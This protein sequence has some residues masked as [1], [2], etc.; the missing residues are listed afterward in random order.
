MARRGRQYPYH[1]TLMRQR[2]CALVCARILSS[3]PGTTSLH[4]GTARARATQQLEA[5]ASPAALQSTLAAL[6]ACA[7][8]LP[9]PA[10][11]LRLVGVVG[12]LQQLAHTEPA[13]VVACSGCSPQE[14]QRL[15]ELFHG[16]LPHA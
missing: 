4:H 8:G 5:A 16:V 3:T 15:W 14:A 12:S 10:L 11:L 9:P 7:P 1:G 6:S 13:D 2:V